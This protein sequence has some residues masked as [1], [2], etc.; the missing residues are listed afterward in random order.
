MK[1]SHMAEVADFIKRIAVDKEDPASVKIDVANFR[2]D[3]N[4]IHYCFHP[5]IDAYKH[6]K[7]V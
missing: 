1:E 7:L 6:Y 3:F 5:D 4:K 2:K